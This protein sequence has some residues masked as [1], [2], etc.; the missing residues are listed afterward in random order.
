[1]WWFCDQCLCNVKI[2]GENELSNIKNNL[3]FIADRKM[4]ISQH[5]RKLRSIIW[6]QAQRD[7]RQPFQTNKKPSC[8]IHDTGSF[9]NFTMYHVYKASPAKSLIAIANPIHVAALY[10]QKTCFIVNRHEETSLVLCFWTNK[11][12]YHWI[13]MM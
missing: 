13:G 10:C 4:C 1:M 5:A 9:V 12:I 7:W 3:P 6:E 2:I 8:Y 11:L